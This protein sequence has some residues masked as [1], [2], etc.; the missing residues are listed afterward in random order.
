MQDFFMIFWK[1]FVNQATAEG[2]SRVRRPRTPDRTGTGMAVSINL[3]YKSRR[4]VA[5]NSNSENEQ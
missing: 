4:G 1:I 5:A 2:N 3:M